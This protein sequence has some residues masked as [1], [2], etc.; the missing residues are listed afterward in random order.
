RGARV[1]DAS[2]SAGVEG[3]NDG[4]GAAG[5]R[6]QDSGP[7]EEGAV[8]ETA[9]LD[10]EETVVGAKAP[11]APGVAPEAD[12]GAGDR[13]VGA[14]LEE[15]N[16]D[17]GESGSGGIGSDVLDRPPG[18]VPGADSGGCDVGSGGVNTDGAGGR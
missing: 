7:G 4:A 6:S 15:E 1:P 16:G 14:A 12:R 17:A 13:P 18:G 10:A 9:G 11:P 8:G 5:Q 2:A 3:V